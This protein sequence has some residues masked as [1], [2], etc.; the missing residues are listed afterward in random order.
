MFAGFERW[1]KQKQ[2]WW[3]ASS[4]RVCC[5]SVSTFCISICTRKEKVSKIL[6]IDVMRS[7]RCIRN[8]SLGCERIR[9]LKP[10]LQR[11]TYITEQYCSFHYIM[12]SKR[13]WIKRNKVLEMVRK[14]HIS[15]E[16][17]IQI[18]WRYFDEIY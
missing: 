2:T 14:S 6:F 10:A 5:G 12:P 1:G 15:P 8:C 11:R 7:G 4:S 9:T 18:L 16:K 13:K 3:A 17:L